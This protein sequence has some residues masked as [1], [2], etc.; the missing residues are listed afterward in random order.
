[1]RRLPPD[2]LEESDRRCPIC[3]GRMFITRIEE[4]EGDD[5]EECKTCGYSPDFFKPKKK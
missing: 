1:M 5:F 2:M 4:P 3:H